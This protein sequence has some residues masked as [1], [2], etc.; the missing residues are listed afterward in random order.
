VHRAVRE[1]P[2]VRAASLSTVMLFSGTD[3]RTLLDIPGYRP[4][5]D[6]D[7]FVRIVA[8]SPGYFDTTG[9]TLL[10][11]R[12]VEAADSAEAESAPIVLGGTLTGLA[13]AWAASRIIASFLFGI[14]PTDT[15]TMATA[16]LVLVA[17]SALAVYIPL[18]HAGPRRS[19]DRVASGLIAANSRYFAAGGLVYSRTWPSFSSRSRSA[20]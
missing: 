1:I 14:T 13:G 8:V 7:I 17:V 15:V 3:W 10:A 19:N 12:A 4:R 6:E 2:G 18:R 11:G 5:G 9:M 20:G 16:T